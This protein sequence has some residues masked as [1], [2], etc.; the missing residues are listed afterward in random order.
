VVSLTANS[1][2][3]NNQWWGQLRHGGLLLSPV[4]LREYLPDGPRSLQNGVYEKLRDSYTVFEAKHDD[5][6][7]G[8]KS[9]LLR[10][11]DLVFQDLLGYPASSWQKETEVIERFKT[12]S[13]SGERLRPNRVLLHLA[14]ENKPRFLLKIDS[15]NKRIGMGRGQTEFSK[16]LTLLRGTKVPLG[17]L[18]NGYQFRLVY[19]GMDHDSWVEWD[20]Q[21][22]FEEDGDMLVAGF[23]ELMG[24]RATTPTEDADYPLLQSV[25]ESRTRQGELSQVLGEQVRSAVEKFLSNINKSLRGNPEILEIL[26]KRPD[27]GE[28]ISEKECME[29]L[30]QASIR[31]I[32]RLVVC[33]FAES[34]ELLPRSMEVYNISYGVEGLYSLLNSAN[35]AEGETNLRESHSA[36]PRLF[37]LFHLIY[38]GSPF[39]DI[40]VPIYNGE[41]FR[42]GD[43]E[44][45]N[46][47]QRAIAIF[48]DERV[49]LDDYVIFQI[50]NLLKIGKFRARKGRSSTW[51]SGPVDFSELRT[52]YIGM[53]Y[54]GLLDYTLK[55]VK[56]EEE[57]VVFLNLGIQPA[58]PLSLLRGL[59][60]TELKNLITTLKKEKA[61]GPKPEESE[62]E[63]GTTEEEA[64][65]QEEV[66]EEEEIEEPALFFTED[67]IAGRKSLDWAKHAVEAAGLIK[68]SMRKGID[69]SLYEN[70]ITEAAN[71]LILRVLAPGEMYLV[72]WSGTRKGTG[73]FYTK[74][75]L[76]VPTVH[77]TLEDLVYTRRD[78]GVSIPKPP[79]EIL[80]LK[81][82]DPAMGSAS[83][84]VAAL[85][86]L[87]DAL[88]DSL[89]Y[90]KKIR[91]TPDRNVIVTV[92]PTGSE[93]KG[94]IT[95]EFA[96]VP[97]SDE[98][99]ESM[100][101]ARLKRYI[102][103]RCI[104]GVDINP[105][106]VELAKL[107]LWVETMD[108]ELP[109]TFLDH[110]LRVGNSLVG[111]WFD[112]FMEYPALAWMREGG[113]KNHSNGVHYEK[114]EWTKAIKKVLNKK[115]KPE[116]VE[117]IG[118]RAG[119]SSLQF[120]DGE[121]ESVENILVHVRSLVEEIHKLSITGRGVEQR[122]L[123]FNEKLQ[124]DEGYQRLKEALDLW[125]SVWFWPADKL[126]VAPTPKNFYMPL[127]E[128]KTIYKELAETLRFFHWE[129]EFPDVFNLE[130]HGF[131]AVLGNPPWEISKP[132][133]KEFFTVFDP[134]Y[135]MRGKQ[136]AIQMQKRF[137]ETDQEIENN[138]LLY[139]ANFKSMSNYTKFSAHPFGDP[140]VQGTQ[141]LVLKKGKENDSIHRLWRDQ[142]SKHIGYSDTA[143]PYLH[144]GSADLNTYKMFL[145][146]GHMLL[147]DAGHL[148]MIVPSGV[149]TDQ[150]STD[151]RNLFL[152][153]SQW[154]WLFGFE[155]RKGIFGI[156]RS[157]KFCTV[158]IVK[159]G[160]TDEINTA[161]MH[162]DLADWEAAQKYVMPYKH[163]QV[164]QFS[165]YSKSLL[166]IRSQL[167]LEILEKIYRNSVLIG[168]S[169]EEGWNIKY[170]TEFHMTNDSK[171][172][173]PITRWLEEGYKPDAY[174]RWVGPNGDIALPL[175]EGRMIGQFDF[176]EK[177][178]VSGKGRSAVWRDIPFEDKKV[179][180]Q[181]LINKSAYNSW[182]AFHGYKVGFMDVTSATNTRSMISCMLVDEPCGNK[183]PVLNVLNSDFHHSLALTSILNSFSFDFA[184][185]NRL[186]GTTLNFFILE[187]APINNV[188]INKS[189]FSH[190]ST[191]CAKL[192][193]INIQLANE[194]LILKKLYP[195]IS[196][197]NWKSLW[198]ITPHERLRLRCILDAIVAELYGLSYSD[199]AYI[200]R[201]D[202]T[203]P[204]G[205]WRV[206]KD[207]PKELRHTTL[208]L[209]AFKHLKEVGLE[210]FCDE[211]WQ[212]PADIQ[213]KLGPR[214]LPWQLEGT[215]EES[216]KECEMHARNIL[217][218][219][220]YENLFV[221]TEIKEEVLLEKSEWRDR[222]PRKT[223]LFQWID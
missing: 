186:G 49:E 76:A 171:L 92:L 75:Q 53:M 183:V 121:P 204:K 88:F 2:S 69:E 68:K 8:D 87:T 116:L 129:L 179:E 1:G 190:L 172:F 138:W 81:V 164:E 100:L 137:F 89:V 117:V 207:K 118:K 212:F 166:E 73:T 124:G 223:T 148:G 170:A 77:R 205:F 90:H 209:L 191:S 130:R 203:D 184:I 216:W 146:T 30:Y 213:E 215:P 151:L 178:W 66:S 26:L 157:F 94:D 107:A 65:E 3:D 18:T 93:S 192:I 206:D 135:R 193:F 32:M 119:Q 221:N 139:N 57:A 7:R 13:A 10:W 115:V 156:H 99:F 140:E 21:Q 12:Q 197:Y 86:Y 120:F 163:E 106:A 143:H 33:L 200:L 102:V 126:D 9:S 39:E 122:E 71:H 153:H 25:L 95:E 220:G 167:D 208:A 196:N 194:W 51:V 47:V 173:P 202:P 63:T 109:F 38:N 187:E 152:E 60:D 103:E 11:L 43:K 50:L 72:R 111:A 198:A 158:V 210:K 56:E 83:F 149:Y 174:G 150:G 23:V 16:F 104:Y 101:K 177:G 131:D 128:T 45:P 112:T 15:E 217:G 168:D 48:E 59:D 144:L 29:A 54:E 14:D 36:W 46:A 114:E 82:C 4:I 180:P 34:R 85:R 123:C 219:E 74:P 181:Y 41:L 132:N 199:F 154:T 80:D 79:E 188:H 84:L 113:D 19:A 61:T 17:I 70:E 31:V 159:G 176:S 165:P 55:Q 147:R 37:S 141:K 44:S 62:E 195:E 67:E 22:W 58:L 133:S 27:T 6:E 162:H 91:D 175:Y 201:D 98:R 214:F 105:L 5:R 222:R 127:E 108:R 40:P 211:D 28:E 96:G 161:F 24:N 78:D 185:R 218:D 182:N 42:P 64:S 20:T 189:A 97:S 155:N 52:E 145:E 134:V 110:K 35:Q 160:K 169:S 136:E 142:R 125:C